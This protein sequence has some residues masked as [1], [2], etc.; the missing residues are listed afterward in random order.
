MKKLLT[1]VLICILCLS[2][3]ALA[4]CGDHVHSYGKWEVTTPATCEESGERSRTCSECG[5]TQ[6]RTIPKLGHNYVNGVCTECGA[7]E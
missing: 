3:L 6:T 5:D 7:E 4:A 2:L 1:I